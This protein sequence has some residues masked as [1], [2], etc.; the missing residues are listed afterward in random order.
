MQRITNHECA[1]LAGNRTLYLQRL[2]RRGALYN[3]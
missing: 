2:G 1:A 3:K